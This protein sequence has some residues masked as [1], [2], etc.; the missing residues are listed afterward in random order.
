MAAPDGLD[1]MLADLAAMLG[2]L[3]DVHTLENP[4]TPELH[5]R[6]AQLLGEA[7]TSYLRTAL[8]QNPAYADWRVLCT[9]GI[10][11]DARRMLHELDPELGPHT[12]AFS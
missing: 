12:G 10:L 8:A 5:A 11:E 3:A 6:L 9:A 4:P 7:E 2:D 1:R